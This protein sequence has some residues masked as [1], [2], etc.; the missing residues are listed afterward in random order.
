MTRI[1]IGIAGY[2]DASPTPEVPTPEGVSLDQDDT[3]GFDTSHIHFILSIAAD[4]S[5]GVASNFLY[6]YL[7]ERMP[8]IKSF[9]IGPKEVVVARESI[10]QAISEAAQNT[11]RTDKQNPRW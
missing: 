5:L 1:L 2:A 4:V 7:K 6:D 10:A 9:F 3:L 11:K 8:Q